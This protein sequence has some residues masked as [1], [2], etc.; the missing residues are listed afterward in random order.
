MDNVIETLQ[1]DHRNLAR[2]LD[3]VDAELDRFAAGESA[4]LELLA[5][6]LDYALN[7]PDLIHHPLEDAIVRRLSAKESAGRAGEPDI[8]AEHRALGQAAR[9]FA[10]AIAHVARDAGMPRDAFVRIGRDFVEKNRR[11][12]ASEE[13]LLLPRALAQLGDEDWAAVGA[14][15][16]IDDPLF[17]QKPEERYLRLLERLVERD[18]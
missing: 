13:Q 8:A 18:G 12:M 10:A 1:R 4:D 14:E 2:L 7:Y 15:R 3:L 16:R 11:H 9:S 6:V 17:G 5:D